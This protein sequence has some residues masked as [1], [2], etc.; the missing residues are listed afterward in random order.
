MEEYKS[1]AELE[2]NLV[3]ALDIGTRSVIGVAGVPERGMLRVL[4]VEEQEH[5]RR[6]VI[7]GQIEDIGQ[8]ALIAREVKERLEQKLGFSLREVSIAAAGRALKT[9]EAEFE[10]ELDE[11][12]SIGEKQVLELETGAIQRAYESLDTGDGL[13]FLCVGHSVVNY[14]LDEYEMST[15]M[16]HRGRRARVR[17]IATFLPSQVVESLYAVTMK[18]GLTVSSMTLEPIAAMNAVIP[19]ELR[20]LNLALVD[21]GGG[22]SDIA[23]SSGGS[24]V[25]YT[26]AT[27]AGDEITETIMRECLVDFQTAE[28][29][30]LKLSEAPETILYQDILGYTYELPIDELF[31]RIRP[32]VESLADEIAGRILEVNG[33]KPPAAVFLVGGGCQI[34]MLCELLAERLNVDSK[35]VAIGGN[36]YMK[37]QVV[38]ELDITGPEYATPV[39]IAVTA[40]SNR[41]ERGFSASVNGKKVTLLR[42][43]GSTVLELLLLSGC[44]YSQIMGRSGAN[45]AYQLNGERRIARGTPSVPAE[46]RVNGGIASVSTAIHPDDEVQFRPAQPGVDA[47]PTVESELGRTAVTVRVAGKDQLFYPHVTIN[48]ISAEPSTRIQN[49]DMVETHRFDTPAELC[50]LMLLPPELFR[51]RRN[52]EPCGPE[53]RLEGGDLLEALPADDQLSQMT[54]DPSLEPEAYEEEEA[55]FQEEEIPEEEPAPE[56]VPAPVETVPEPAPV[57]EQK[58]D[59]ETAPVE[60]PRKGGITIELNG[61]KLTLP[62][63]GDGAPYQFVDMLNF[64][65]VDLSKPQGNIILTLNSRNA[66]FLDLVRTGDQVTIAWDVRS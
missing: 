50:R 36:N 39:G 29:I 46:L 48:G 19:R 42:T 8:T 37:R 45:V 61:K 32:A 64:V 59:P 65:D 3:F 28:E 40:M 10:L 58:A 17:I 15:L 38:T 49:G 43:G 6:A 55:P 26:M 34:P 44:Q 63:K 5:I 52:G 13:S 30:K 56:E 16:D 60:A 33:E 51:F 22:T 25:A 66:S 57:P 20:M 41:L 31:Q 18:I 27:T 54:G 14:W 35:K 47:A 7:D 21:V 1:S 24:V 11:R 23:I 62:P 2:R 9:Q 12:E 4:A 53:E